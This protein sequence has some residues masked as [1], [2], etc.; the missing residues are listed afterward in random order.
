MPPAAY[1]SL[2]YRGMDWPQ[3]DL[4][5]DTAFSIRYGLFISAPILLLA[6]NIPGWFRG[7][8]ILNRPE[9]YFVLAFSLLFF[10]F[11]A[12][13]QYGR[14][15]FNSGVRH[16][17]PVTPFLFLLAAG[18]LMRMPALVSALIGL[19]ATYWSWC[20]A[21]Y[22]DVEH[23]LGVMESVI[24]VTLEGFRFPWLFPR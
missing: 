18:V 9:L 16:V 10:L 13:N 24:H 3:L 4:F 23:G 2:G 6:L 15:Q 12:A 11:C 14:M 5:W 22:R 7:Q 21:M 20:L 17:V 1:T 8:R 19:L